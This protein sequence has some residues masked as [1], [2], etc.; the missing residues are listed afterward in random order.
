MMLTPL[1]PLTMTAEVC[2]GYEPIAYATFLRLRFPQ[3]MA[4]TDDDLCN[5]LAMQAPRVLQA[6][7]C[8]WVDE[9]TGPRICV[10]WAWCLRFGEPG[11]QLAPGGFS[12][13]VMFVEDDGRHLGNKRTEEILHA[14]LATKPWQATLREGPEYQRFVDRLN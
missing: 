12:S 13:N 6:G 11:E 10:G 4:F 1:R 2:P 9:S 14:W 7:F 5:E 8:D 3:R